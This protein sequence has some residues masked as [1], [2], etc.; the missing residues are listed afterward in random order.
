MTAYVFNVNICTFL[1]CGSASA[2]CWFNRTHLLDLPVTVILILRYKI[3][4]ST[5]FIG[6]NLA[7]RVKR[8]FGDREHRLTY[9][10]SVCVYI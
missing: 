6:K 3:Q 5:R 4:S 10:G 9:W 1:C 8:I 2:A 7:L